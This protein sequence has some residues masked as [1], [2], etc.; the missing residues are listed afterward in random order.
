[1]SD[2]IATEAIR[3]ANGTRVLSVAG[4]VDIATAGELERSLAPEPTALIVDLTECEFVDSS[5]AGPLVGAHKRL[6]ADS[7]PLALVSADERILRVFK[8]TGLDRLL[9]IYPTRAAALRG[10]GHVGLA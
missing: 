1:M 7:G 4:T 10:G 5:V 8:I 6:A 2:S 9:A 3:L